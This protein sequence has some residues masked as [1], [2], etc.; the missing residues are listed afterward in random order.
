MAVWIIAYEKQC[1][2]HKIDGSGVVSKYV[3][4]TEKNLS[5]IFLKVWP[6]NPI[7]FIDRANV[8][9]GKR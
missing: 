4:E 8:L 1:D 3:G 9:S 7:L 2:R 5:Q 6:N